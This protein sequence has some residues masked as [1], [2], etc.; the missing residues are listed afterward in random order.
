MGFK[1][2]L[3]RILDHRIDI[4]DDEKKELARRNKYY[5]KLLQDLKN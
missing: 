5:R 2:K 4:L 1:Y 3:Q